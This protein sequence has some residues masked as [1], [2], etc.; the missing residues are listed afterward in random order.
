MAHGG[1]LNG[2]EIVSHNKKYRV[3]VV[4]G[5]GTWGRHYL[6]AYAL[7]P[8]CEIVGLVDLARER[9]QLFADHFGITKLY[10]TMDELLAE[11]VPDIVSIILPVAYSSHAVIACA[12]A[13]VRVV[14]C[15]K[16]IAV[17]L[18]EA[19]EMVRICR[20]R[21]TAL[22]CATCYW[23][24]PYLVEVAEWLRAGNIGRLTAAAIPVGLTRE[25]SGA[26]CVPLT[27]MRLVTGM[28]VEWVEGWALP[29]ARGHPWPPE[30]DETE[31]DCPA[32]GRLGL[33][34][35]II[36]EV[37]EPRFDE[38]MSCLVAVVGENGQAWLGYP[39]PVL[40]R[41]AGALSTPVYPEFFQRPFE[42]LF[43][44]AIKRLMRAFDTGE[45]ALCSGHDYRQALEI[46]IALKLSDKR[47]HE[48]VYLPLEDRSIR[49]FPA[50]WRW[51]GGDA[52]GWE[53]G[54]YPGPPGIETG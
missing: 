41:G 3:A 49:I 29:P 32:F 51:K 53:A 5:A 20:E 42:T 18:R 1:S 54:N 13:G 16:P 37:P 22:G 31:L 50:P 6:R 34:G 33:S 11:R 19:D 15:E 25:V 12:E 2:G 26:G 36:C 23:E 35:G 17:S 46:A 47:G 48:R 40:V 52:V 9:R 28:E 24:I 21:G 8:D 4:G 30:A 10:D 44:P 39:R 27:Q 43:G 7:H 38:S 14:S 45:E